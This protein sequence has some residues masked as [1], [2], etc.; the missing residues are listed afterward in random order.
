MFLR[1][2]A[3]YMMMLLIVIA[4]SACGGNE[5]KPTEGQ[6]QSKPVTIKVVS[7]WAE[8]NMMNDGLWMLKE[9]VEK[10]SNGSII[11]EWIGGPE[12]VPPFE[13][14]ESLRAGIT[15]VAWTAHTYNVSQIPVVEGAKLSELTPSEERAKGAADFYDKLYLDKLNAKY[16]G[17]GT[18]NFG[19]NFYTNFEVN[20][21]DDFKGKTIRVTPAYAAFADA[22]G[23]APVTTDPGEVYAALERNMVVGYGWPAVGIMNFGW[24]EVT[25]YVIEPSFYQVDVIALMSN[26]AW[27]K[28]SSEQQ[29][30]LL[31]SIIEAEQQAYE[32][33][34]SLVSKERKAL[35]EKGVNI[36]Q[37]DS[38]MASEYLQIANDSGWARVLNNDPVNGA[39]LQDLLKK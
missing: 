35:E 9:I 33:F 1:K 14:G 6:Q 23:A 7:A 39:K 3:Y 24:D 27:D 5:Q 37:L 29:G 11:L 16:L 38:A 2:L 25:T 20:K 12:A 21:L 13:L 17:K 30:I 34:G 26:N 28:L 36:I 31:G 8:Q 32:H 15:D 4:V 10:K 22:L 19:F 18:P